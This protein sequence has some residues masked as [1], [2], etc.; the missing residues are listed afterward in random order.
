MA[1]QLNVTTLLEKVAADVAD[2]KERFAA[3]D[4][5]VKGI[6]G[7]PSLEER[8]RLYVDGRDEH[9]KKNAQESVRLVQ[10]VLEQSITIS[11][12]KLHAEI[13]ESKAASQANGIKLD[14]TEKTRSRDH[15]EN[16]NRHEAS[17]KKQE[18]TSRVVNIGIGLVLA[19]Q[20][21]IA[22]AIH[23]K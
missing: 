10:Q 16:L 18:K 20:A 3:L 17:E 11:E 23:V 19:A 1:E 7:P 2:T 14:E 4:V 22:Y 13:L 5:H 9:G 6:V 21:Y 12:L 15:L 8:L